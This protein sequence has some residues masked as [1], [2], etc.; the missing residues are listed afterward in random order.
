[1]FVSLKEVVALGGSTEEILGKV[2]CILAIVFNYGGKLFGVRGSI[3]FNNIIALL[4]FSYYLRER[5]APIL[6]IAYLE[7]FLYSYGFFGKY[8][9]SILRKELSLA[10]AL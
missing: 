8:L 6:D 7:F 1:M 9:Y 4:V 10:T 5:N 2:E 3:E